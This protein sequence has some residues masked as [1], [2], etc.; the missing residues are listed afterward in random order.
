MKILLEGPDGTGKSTLANTLK[1]RFGYEYI[2]LSKDDF[3]KGCDTDFFEKFY[4]LI[5][6]EDNIIVDRAIFSNIIYGEVFN[7]G[8][9]S[10]TLA[11]LIFSEFDWA[12]ICLPHNKEKYLENFNMLKNEREEMF[13]NMTEVYDRFLELYLA[14][15]HKYN[16]VRYDMFCD[17]SYFIP[18]IK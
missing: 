14:L 7:N 10:K 3:D 11:D 17:P 6:C 5:K 18:K 9:I 8:C 4:E 15:Q 12:I 2:H 13:S 16:V 1:E